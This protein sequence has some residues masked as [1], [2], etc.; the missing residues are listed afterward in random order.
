MSYPVPWPPSFET[1]I[2]SY[3]ADGE[4]VVTPEARLAEFGLDSMTTVSLILDL[5]AQYSVQ[6]PDEELL[7]LT[8]TD[9]RRMWDVLERAGAPGADAETEGGETSAPGRPGELGEGVEIEPLACSAQPVESAATLSR[10]AVD[11]GDPG[12]R[13]R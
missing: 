13:R 5:E 1:L 10:G 9:L 12:A 7:T 2:K 3:L 11:S 4:S 8:N 6:I